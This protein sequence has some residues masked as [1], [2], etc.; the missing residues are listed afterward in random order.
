MQRLNPIQQAGLPM[1][2]LDSVLEKEHIVH[3]LCLP[4]SKSGLLLSE[5]FYIPN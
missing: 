4:S 5:D 3:K 1:L 2:A